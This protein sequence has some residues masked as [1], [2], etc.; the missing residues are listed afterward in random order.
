MSIRSLTEKIPNFL[1]YPQLGISNSQLEIFAQ[2]GI[3]DWFSEAALPDSEIPNHQLVIVSQTGYL[4]SPIGDNM[5][6][7][8]KYAQFRIFSFS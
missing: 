1:Q 4:I 6:N 7:L 5:A 2:L 3:W 8:V